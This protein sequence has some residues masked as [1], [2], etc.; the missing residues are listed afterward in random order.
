[1]TIYLKDEATSKAV[2]KLA[3]RDGVTLTEAVRKAVN[4][5]L[6]LSSDDVEMI[7]LRKLQDMVASHRA[8]GKLAD[9]DFYDSL[10][11]D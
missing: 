8:T 9:K 3:K 5:E 6:A 11:E 10:Y 1:M 4:K 2:R 7:A